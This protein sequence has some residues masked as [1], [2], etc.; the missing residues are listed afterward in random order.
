MSGWHLAQINIARAVAPIDD[1]VMA[2]FVAQ[3]DAINAV[4]DA[5]PG[6]VWRLQ[7]ESGNATDIQAY[8]DPRVIINMSVWE[9]AEALFDYVYKSDHLSVLRRRKDWFDRAD[10]PIMAMWWIEAGTTPSLEDAV[11]RLECLRE[12]GST[13]HAFSFKEQF[14]PPGSADGGDPRHSPVLVPEEYCDGW[15]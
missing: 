15:A 10:Q 12:Q 2:E 7:S 8:A 6:F 13:S 9:S 14:P 1:P 11:A 4:A 3:L 5:S